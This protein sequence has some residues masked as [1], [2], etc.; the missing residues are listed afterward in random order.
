MLMENNYG[1]YTKEDLIK[2]L[3]QRDQKI[4]E[5]EE[6]QKKAEESANLMIES[7]QKIKGLVK[8]KE[9]EKAESR[10]AYLKTLVERL[11]LKY[12]KKLGQYKAAAKKLYGSNSERSVNVSRHTEPKKR[13]SRY[14]SFIRELKALK[15]AIECRETDVDFAAIGLD[16]DSY[17]KAEG[18]STLKLEGFPIAIKPVIEESAKYR[19]KK[20]IEPSG[21]LPA[22]VSAT[23]DDPYHNSVATPSLLATLLMLKLV[24]GVPIYRVAEHCSIKGLRIGAKTMD[25]L[26]QKAL[27]LLGPVA[28]LVLERIKGCAVPIVHADETTLLVTQ[29]GKTKGYVYQLTASR[30][31]APACY[32]RYTGSR[33]SE[34]IKPDLPA[35]RK[36]VLCCDGFSGY[37]KLARENPETYVI[38]NCNFHARKLFVEANDALDKSLRKDSVSGRIIDAYAAIFSE[39]SRMETMQPSQRLAIRQ[40]EGYLAKVGTLKRL[41]EGIDARSGTLLSDA[42]NYFVSREDTLFRYLED[43][44]L[45]MTNN[46]AERHFKMFVMCRRNCLHARTDESARRLT[47]GFS[48]VGTAMDCG[49]DLFP[50]FCEVFDRLPR[51]G[52]DPRDLV[53]WNPEMQKKYGLRHDSLDKEN[54]SEG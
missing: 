45:D 46:L 22:I 38:Q 48:V 16:R 49:I 9:A 25:Q 17:E 39:E 34:A 7:F 24:Y 5:L 42:K 23:R 32:F 2:V 8:K 30:Y 27:A 37:E 10:I 53:P 28:D 50:Y 3:L 20:G 33:S 40:S 41:V 47:D 15:D 54:N 51:K 14:N 13:G 36:I 26:L 1:G 29:N 18:D 35:G 6:K 43:G 31:D 19:L 4:H 11:I 52:T 12:E 44:Y 21:E